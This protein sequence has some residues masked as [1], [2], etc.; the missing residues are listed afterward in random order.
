MV[1]SISEDEDF[2]I[3]GSEDGKL[4][5]WNKASKYAPAINPVF[6][7]Y[8]KDHNDSF[9][10]FKPFNGMMVTS[11]Q[12]APYNVVQRVARCF[13]EYEPAGVV[14]KIIVATSYDGRMKVF[15]QVIEVQ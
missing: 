4:C 11:A 9:E 8:N 7:G 13:L 3:S 10:Y 6:T 2:V 12:F 15:Y 14:K 5:M 1:A